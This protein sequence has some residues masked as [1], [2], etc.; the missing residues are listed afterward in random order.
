MS[1]EERVKNIIVE[2]INT[3]ISTLTGIPVTNPAVDSVYDDYIQ[4]G[5]NTFDTARRD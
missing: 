5:G 2:E 4:R 3:S 1:V